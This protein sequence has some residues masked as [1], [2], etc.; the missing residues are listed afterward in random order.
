MAEA[1]KQAEERAKGAA[2]KMFD[3]YRFV[4]VSQ[5]NEATLAKRRLMIQN[6]PPQINDVQLSAF[7]NAMLRECGATKPDEDALVTCWATVEA[8]AT[9]I[10]LNGI[11]CMGNNIKI[12]Y[13]AVEAII[14]TSAGGMILPGLNVPGAPGSEIEGG[15]ISASGERP[16]G[17]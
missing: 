14:G 3:G 16:L 6:L 2:M 15:F 10:A 5:E 12:M 1:K 13:R 11:S 17:I 7:L 9:A 8:A 4:E